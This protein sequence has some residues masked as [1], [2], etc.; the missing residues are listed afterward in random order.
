MA[1]S[2]LQ[3]ARE[4]ENEDSWSK[5]RREAV[6]NAGNFKVSQRRVRAR[7]PFVAHV[8]VLQRAAKLRLPRLGVVVTVAFGI[9]AVQA[10]A[11][12]QLDEGMWRLGL[13]NSGGV[14]QGSRDRSGDY[15]LVGFV[16]YEVPAT[17]RTT[18]G[19]RLM[20]LFIYTQ[21]QDGA[22]DHRLLRDFFRK[23]TG[24]ND[25][26]WGAGLGLVG[27]VYQVKDE[28]RGWYGEAGVTPF[29]HKNRFIANSSNLNFLITLATGYQF[30]SDWYI[31]AHYQHISNASL[32]RRNSGANALG[33][34][35]GYR[36]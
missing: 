14:Y 8:R 4:A 26:V 2:P 21:N 20:P 34:G 12:L 35:I 36:F 32:G 27:R 22:K 7:R 11:G 5:S 28:Y 29:V 19:L 33:I 25:T 1:N 16:D 24:E 18:L 3:K 30:K 6:G 23:T 13:N 10:H 31:Q 15:S 17:P 9:M